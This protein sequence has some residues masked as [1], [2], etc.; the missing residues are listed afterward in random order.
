MPIARSSLAGAATGVV[1]L[2]GAVGFGVGLPEVVENPGA[3]AGELP[4]LPDRL[5]ARFVSVSSSTP[6]DFKA[7][8]PEDVADAE[9]IAKAFGDAEKRAVKG[10][11]GVYGDVEVRYYRDI[12]ASL[13]AASDPTGQTAAAEMVVTVVPGPAGPVLPQGPFENNQ[14]GAHYELKKLGGHPCAV[15]WVEAIDPTTNAPTGEEPTGANYQ[16]ECH[17]QLDGVTFDIVSNGL[18]PKEYVHYVELLLELTEEG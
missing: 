16:I 15:Q 14:N 9:E 7:D 8:S 12:E 5:D 10:L 4:K 3:T 1:L 17:A 2:A 18:D 6:N 13:A 11:A